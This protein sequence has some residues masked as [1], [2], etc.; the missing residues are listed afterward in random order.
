M[1]IRRSDLDRQ[2]DIIEA[3][4][5]QHKIRCRVDGAVVT[6]RFVQFHLRTTADVKVRRV[7]G[8]AEEI[9]LALRAADARIYRSR[10]RIHIE[11]PRD[12][13]ASVKLL[14]L[15]DRLP[16]LPAATAVLGLDEQGAPLLLRIVSPDVAHV[17]VAGMTGS[18]KTALARTLLASLALGNPPASLHLI[19]IDPKGRGFAPLV[20]LPHV[21]G[22]LATS[23][24]AALA[25]LD[26]VVAEMERRDRAGQSRPVI[27]VAIDELA[28]LVQ[29]GG[30]AAQERVARLAQR[31]R[32]AGI[33]LVA[34]T[35]KPT[36]ALI[37][38]A[39]K[40]NFPVRLV[41]A[42]NGKDEAR[43]A[44][45][46]PDSGAEKLGGKGD[47]LLVAKGETI[48]FQAAW[49]DPHEIRQFAQGTRG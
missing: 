31:G 15:L 20:R 47:F 33:H 13:P 8:L 43:Y 19:L 25:C 38:S 30:K 36:A 41:G 39:V 32:E 17:L 9:A 37:G 4:L 29:T 1:A 7:M 12:G 40:A 49:I 21:W 24:E 18:G 14:P 34:C 35:Q 22:E 5:G 23:V 11:V 16:S 27:V 3:V 6:P 44:T 2:A 10:G 45:G 26:W 46:I 42:V 28:D 48:R